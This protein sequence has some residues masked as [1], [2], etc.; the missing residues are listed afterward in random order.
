MRRSRFVTSVLI[1]S[2][3]LASAPAWAQTT[4]TGDRPTGTTVDTMTLRMMLDKGVITQA[5][6][7]SAVHDL[8]DTSGNKAG[9]S[10]N[11][12]VGKFSATL[13]GFAEA[14]FMEDSTQ[15]FSDVAGSG[16]VARPGT[17]AG[18]N[19]RSQF[20]VRNT[21]I[22]FRF[23]APEYHRMRATAQIETDFL[24]DWAN[25][26]YTGATGQ[27]S[28][29]QFF[30]NPALRVRHAF[31]KVENPVVD[32][33]FGQ[34]WDVFGGGG[35]YHPNSVQIQGIPGEI[36]A[37]TPQLRLSKTVGNKDFRS[38]SS[39]LRYARRTETRVCPKVRASFASR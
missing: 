28:E 8:F 7:D 23:R 22:G 13:Y 37:R 11:L 4:S 5:E 27:P 14:D 38:T 18:G 31:L 12:V 17:Y 36:Y 35:V 15:S 10:Q 2:S 29:N 26:T 19:P 25:P 16:Q 1:V 34:T 6:Y 39:P 20:S 3:A 9:E 30:T 33:L 21:R 32:V 24:G